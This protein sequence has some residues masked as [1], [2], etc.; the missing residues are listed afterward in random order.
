MLLVLA[1]REHGD[2]LDEI[3]PFLR[4]VFLE[5]PLA[6]DAVGHADHRQRS[7]GQVRQHAGRNLCEVGH[8]IALGE[9][10]KAL[11]RIGRPV[12][13]IE[14]SEPDAMHAHRQRECR[15][16]ARELAH[17]VVDRAAGRIRR[18][19]VRF[20][21]SHRRWIDVVAKAQEDRRAQVTVLG[22]ALKVHFGD[23]FRR[24]PGRRAIELRRLGEGAG[25]ALQ[26]L[27]QALACFSVRSSKPEPTCDAYCSFALG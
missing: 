13:A 27:Q 4:P 15:L 20:G 21:T 7:I 26:R 5:K 22:P 16:G 19:K 25:L 23:C 2:G 17:D 6:A 10:G 12:D 3:R 14:V 1:A 11:R 18:R 24:H 8:Q 9:R